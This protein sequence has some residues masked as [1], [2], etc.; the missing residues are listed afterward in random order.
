MFIFKVVF[1]F[2]SGLIRVSLLLYLF[3]I[4]ANSNG[5]Y[6]NEVKTEL[7]S[8]T[9]G[10]IMHYLE[11]DAI[12]T[13]TILAQETIPKIVRYVETEAFAKD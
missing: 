5:G 11:H 8:V 2:I 7:S 4:F 6:I 9:L 13:V 10:E 12:P 3:V 1:F